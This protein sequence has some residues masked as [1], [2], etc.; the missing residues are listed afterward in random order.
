MPPAPSVG[1]IFILGL[2]AGVLAAC[3]PREV[4]ETAEMSGAPAGPPRVEILAPVEGDT[5]GGPV[6]IRLTASG[7]TIAP[8]SGVREE[9]IGHHHLIVNA[10]PTLADQPIPSTAEYIHLGTGVS[11]WTFDSLPPGPH[12]IIA[13]IAWGDH[14][15]IAG[16][17]ADTVRI[18]VR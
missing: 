9:G 10:D 6:T 13:I 3:G 16:A 11:E 5:V 8:A 17:V 2:F 4:P 12:R 18:V 1:R 15:P 7:I 14:V